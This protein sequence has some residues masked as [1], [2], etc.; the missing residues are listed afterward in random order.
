MIVVSGGAPLQPGT[1]E[2]AVKLVEEVQTATRAEAGCISYTFYF[3]VTDPNALHVFEE[4]ESEEALNSHL[5]QEYT[6]SFLASLG[7]LVA[8]PPDVKRYDVNGVSKLI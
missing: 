6:Q 2:W 7:E 3:G 1:V 4:W 8:G 5:Q